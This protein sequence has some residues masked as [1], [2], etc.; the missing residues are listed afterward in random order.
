MFWGLVDI[1][2]TR[3]EKINM[4]NILN[5]CALI[6]VGFLFS[7]CVP[8]KEKNI[9][10][11]KVSEMVLKGGDYTTTLYIPNPDFHRL[12]GA[13]SSDGTVLLNLM[14]PEMIP[15]LE[16]P[17]DLRERGE[18]YKSISILIHQYPK[19]RSIKQF[20]DDNKKYL[21]TTRLIGEEYD[22]MHYSQE[23]DGIQDHRD[24]W[25][26]KQGEEIQS[27]VTCSEKILKTDIPQCSQYIRLSKLSIKF[28]Y[29]KKLLENH[30]E[31]KKKVY[32]LLESYQTHKKSTE[33][34]VERLNKK[35]NEKKREFK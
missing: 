22:L 2:E 17:N 8:E 27:V 35:N 11:F 30:K 31:I 28:S 25:V 23:Q 7:A 4:K 15:I 29:D 16:K 3:K 19:P 26:D 12:T 1:S 20:L 9:L 14:Y 21:R 10:D 33:Y 13:T 34:Y 18:W 32:D 5:I 6:L 24:I